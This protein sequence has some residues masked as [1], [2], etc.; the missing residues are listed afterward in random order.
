MRAH[1]PD[2]RTPVGSRLKNGLRHSVEIGAIQRF[3]LG[4]QRHDIIQSHI[5]DA[6]S[7]GAEN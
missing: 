1:H 5:M 6:L 7:Q 4:L 2:D 3:D